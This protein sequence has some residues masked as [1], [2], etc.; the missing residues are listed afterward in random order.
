MVCCPKP[1]LSQAVLSLWSDFFQNTHLLFPQS[2]LK[3]SVTTYYLA[4][5]SNPST[6]QILTRDKT[7]TLK[8]PLGRKHSKEYLQKRR[9]VP[10]KQPNVVKLPTAGIHH[11]FQR[12]K[13]KG[14][15]HDL[16]ERKPDVSSYLY[17]HNHCQLVRDWGRGGRT[18]TKLFPLPLISQCL[19]PTRK[20]D[21]RSLRQPTK[22]ASQ[23]WSR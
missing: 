20:Q 10:R 6:G 2:C 7:Y 14:T 4:I 21:K 3:P 11:A 19:S 23:A 22:S 5:S 15:W 12:K 16:T 13:S 9:Q 18:L 17:E 1:S 8:M